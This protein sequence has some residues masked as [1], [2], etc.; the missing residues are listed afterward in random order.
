MLA[1]K[2]RPWWHAILPGSSQKASAENSAEDEE[3]QLLDQ[4]PSFIWEMYRNSLRYKQPHLYQNVLLNHI[5]RNAQLVTKKGLYLSIKSHC[6]ANNIDPLLII[7]RTY[8]LAP[9]LTSKS[10]KDDDMEDF[11]KFCEQEASARGVS[12]NDI[13]WIMKP[14][15][16][17]N[18]GFGIKVIEGME[19]VLR[20]VQRG[21]SADSDG[22]E[23]SNEKRDSKTCR[24][25][26]SLPNNNCDG[27]ETALSKAARRIAQQD[28]YIVQLY[29]E[30]PLLIHGR[31]FDIRCYVLV[32][33]SAK[34]ELNAYFFN[35]AYIRTSSKKYS[36]ENFSD[37]ETHLT[38]DA[39]QKN[40]ESY[41]KFEEGNK[42][43]LQ[44]WQNIIIEDYP[45]EPRLHSIVFSHIFPEIKR[46][47]KISVEAVQ[48]AF[49]ETEIPRS[50]ELFGYDYM[51]TSDFQPVL[52]EVNTNPC[53]EFVCPLLTSI[54]SDVIEN[55]V[56]LAV[57][58]VFSP[59]KAQNRTK[60]TEEAI[61]QIESQPLKFEVLLP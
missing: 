54:I 40:S 28:G 48:N 22:S 56:R 59:P 32:M 34:T 60:L 31:K 30:K 43:S 61:Q 50:F 33:V 7:P 57:D 49:L 21:T 3:S 23:A 39:V 29:I 44:E 2:K 41:G 14:A 17:T 52:I 42:L 15:S 1:M 24:K 51:I 19:N 13:V 11:L 16:K 47:S 35:E 12:V 6:V 20:I 46:M 26:S 58:S 8:Y 37:R 27:S 36:L 10:M 9:G 53:L 45:N 5:Q 4:Q 18:R 38:N 25:G 55:T